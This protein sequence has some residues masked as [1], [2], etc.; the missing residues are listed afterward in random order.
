MD[1]WER[2]RALVPVDVPEYVRQLLSETGFDNYLSLEA[3]DDDAMNELV[4]FSNKDPTKTGPLRIGHKLMLLRIRDIIRSK[5]IETLSKFDK[6]LDKQR[7]TST[8]MP[9]P[10]KRYNHKSGVG[11][12]NRDQNLDLNP[13][14][15][16]LRTKIKDLLKKMCLDEVLCGC[17]FSKNN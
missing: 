9:P 8:L 4:A 13:E 11:D 6:E 17:K 14:E 5:G 2:L 16:I 12:Q 3:L 15:L 1:F 7:Q 10:K